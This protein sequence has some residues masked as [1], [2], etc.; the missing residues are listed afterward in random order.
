[1]FREKSQ[2]DYQKKVLCVVMVPKLDIRVLIMKK[3][4]SENNYCVVIYL[5]VVLYGSEKYSAMNKIHVIIHAV[6]C[7]Q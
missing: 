1:M 6:R 5:Q 7:D 4:T 2:Q 3:D